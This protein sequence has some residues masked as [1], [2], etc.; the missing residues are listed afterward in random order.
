M[1]V[2]KNL[3]ILVN[4]LCGLLILLKLLSY[5]NGNIE[6]YFFIFWST[7]IISFLFFLNKLS[8]KSFQ[9][10]SFILLIYFLSSSLR[11]FGIKPMIY[12]LLEIITIV[13]LFI[14]CI[15]APKLIRKN[16]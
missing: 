12:D 6:F 13:I 3:K 16:M 7:P 11:V 5:L 1:L 10:F 9:S 8:I 15:M 4:L 2:N 14:V